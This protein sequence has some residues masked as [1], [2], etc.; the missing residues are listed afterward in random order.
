VI[1]G[2]RV[3]P[4]FE[5]SSPVVPCCGTESLSRMPAGLRQTCLQQAEALRSW[6][7]RINREA[8]G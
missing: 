3:P 8:G 4:A 7:D 6:Q 1:I 2:I 5:S